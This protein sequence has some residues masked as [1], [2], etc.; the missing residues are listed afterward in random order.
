MV[1]R[2]HDVA[3]ASRNPGPK[4]TPVPRNGAPPAPSR[5]EA[6]AF[7]K[8]LGAVGLVI[9]AVVIAYAGSLRNPFVFDDI[10]SITAN[11]TVHHLFPLWKTL[12]SP[13]DAAAT[14]AGRPLLSLSFA[15]NYAI[16][17]ESVVGYHVVNLLI[18]AG[19]A[20]LLFG[21]VRRLFGNLGLA[22]AVAVLWSVHPLQTESVTYIVQ[23]AESLAGLVYLGAVYCFIRCIEGD[24]RTLWAALCV[25]LCLAGMAVKE[26]VATAPVLIL[27]LDRTFYAGSFAQAWRRRRGLYVWLAATWLLLAGLVASTGGNRGGSVGFGLGLDWWG[28]E[29]REA[30]AI[31]QYLK[32]TFYP[33]PLVFDYGLFPDSAAG[34]RLALVIVAGLLAATIWALVKQPKVGLAGAAFFGILAPST[35]VP[36]VNQVVAEH[37]M[38]LPLAAVIALVAVAAVRLAPAWRKTRIALATVA[39][40]ALTATTV[41]RNRVYTSA[42]SLW[43]DTVAKRP[44]NPSASFALG[45][46]LFAAHD[47][48]GAAL[49]F[50]RALQLAPNSFDAHMDLGNALV[51]LHRSGEAAEEFARACELDPASWKAHYN[52]GLLYKNSGQAA[53]AL[54]E[55]AAAAR[56]APDLAVTHFSLADADDV[57]GLE[58]KA[59]AE[60]RRAVELDPDYADAFY[61]LGLLLQKNARYPEAVSA[62][63]E[64]TRLAP[65]NA[66]AFNNLAIVTA[67]SGDFAGSLAAFRAALKIDPNSAATHA[68]LA[69][70]LHV[71]GREN[72][73]QKELEIARRLRP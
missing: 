59:E 45:S 8:R 73:A 72:E 38:Y 43:S 46:A 19:A 28:Y 1:F 42:V 25:L 22:L 20:L 58:A 13:P 10:A 65:K 35:L 5:P 34:G 40:R 60:Y 24:R 61:N 62:F 32:L 64:V 54:P 44:A 7:W 36:G 17:G 30:S 47:F 67:Q 53:R 15:L 18:H 37:R 31:G 16:G 14:T 41:A 27:F 6:P 23:R 57:T 70:A 4:S 12:Y 71:L 29:W 39:A 68:N 52:L 56:L 33:S 55:L 69:R 11:P 21:I 63:R 66:L 9:V 50:R 48:E 2:W 26:V 3:M 51:E 49:R